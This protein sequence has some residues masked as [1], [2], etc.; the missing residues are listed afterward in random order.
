MKTVISIFIFIYI[1]CFLVN[2]LDRMEISQKTCELDT[3]MKIEYINCIE[4]TMSEE[5]IDA[6]NNYMEC[7]GLSSR[8]DYLEE[9]CTIYAG[10]EKDDLY[11]RYSKCYD[12]ELFT[13]YPITTE[14]MRTC[15]EKIT[16]G[17]ME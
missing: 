2:S 15:F 7:L 3:E 5:A 8:L 14:N 16:I 1:T 6:A 9:I 10:E 17:P 11:E 12:E 4:R 13:K